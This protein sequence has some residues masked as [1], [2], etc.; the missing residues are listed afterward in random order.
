MASQALWLP[1]HFLEKPWD[2]RLLCPAGSPVAGQRQAEGR[3][4][5]TG[6][7]LELWFA[8]RTRRARREKWVLLPAQPLT[9]TL[10]TSFLSASR[11][12]LYKG[13]CLAPEEG[14][15]RGQHRTLGLGAPIW[16]WGRG[17]RQLQERCLGGRKDSRKEAL[18]A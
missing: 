8:V 5:L 4:P 2:L 6:L 11:S 16:G 13:S 9:V 14:L 7:W 15:S 10:T 3:T 17:T 18:K 1:L 12:L